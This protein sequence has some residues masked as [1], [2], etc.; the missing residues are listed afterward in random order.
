MDN[1]RNPPYT[2]KE[3]GFNGFM[4]RSIGSSQASSLR[5]AST[6]FRKVNNQTINFDQQQ[7]SGA[8]GDVIQVGQG[9]KID[10]GGNT[11]RISVYDGNTEVVRIGDL[12][13]V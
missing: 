1:R 8:L 2:Y 5:Q 10:G 11:G 4:R 12:G 13:D 3:A 9:V 7:T 6:D